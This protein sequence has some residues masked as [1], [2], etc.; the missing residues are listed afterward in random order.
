D[1]RVQIGRQFRFRPAAQHDAAEWRRNR[2]QTERQS[3]SGRGVEKHYL[4]VPSQGSGCNKTR[5]RGIEK[6][7]IEIDP[8]HGLAGLDPLLV[9][10][11]SK[12]GTRLPVW[13]GEPKAAWRHNGAVFTNQLIRVF[14]IRKP[15]TITAFGK[16]LAKAGSYRVSRLE[17]RALRRGVRLV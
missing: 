7:S 12:R 1:Y 13:R 4:L 2:R 8:Q 3:R 15:Q 14:D 6:P 10:G 11:T 9:V 16:R 17:Q 5:R